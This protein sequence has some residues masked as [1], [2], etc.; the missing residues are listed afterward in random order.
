MSH[1]LYMDNPCKICEMVEGC[2]CGAARIANEITD[3]SILQSNTV[4]VQ[5]QSKKGSFFEVCCSTAVGYLIALLTQYLVFPLFSI[6]TSH[7]DNIL[8]ALI[9]TIV[10]IIRSYIFRRLFNSL[11]K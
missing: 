10:S 3:Y 1:D 11:C 8:I 9:F 5:G 2:R 6:H 4:F 7:Q